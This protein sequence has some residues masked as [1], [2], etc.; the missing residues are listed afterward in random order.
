MKDPGSKPTRCLA[1]IWDL[2]SL[3]ED[4]WT[5]GRIAIKGNDWYPVSE[6]ASSN[7]RGKKG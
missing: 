1:E 5:A 7:I 3:Q 4:R 2:I 6:A